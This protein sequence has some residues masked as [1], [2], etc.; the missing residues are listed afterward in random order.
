MEVLFNECSLIADV[1][2]AGTDIIIA[3]EDAGIIAL[4]S[5]FYFSMLL[6]WL[7]DVCEFI[8]VLPLCVLQS[9][10]EQL[11][12][13]AQHL[14]VWVILNSYQHS[15]LGCNET[16]VPCCFRLISFHILNCSPE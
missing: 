14:F 11:W 15:Q 9:L 1:L 10:A 5:W 16:L 13:F 3:D 6:I 8:S 2:D 7:L 12:L 4:V